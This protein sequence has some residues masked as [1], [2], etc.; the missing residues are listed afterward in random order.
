MIYLCSVNGEIYIESSIELS[1]L[2]AK[3]PGNEL[4]RDRKGHGANWPDSY[5]RLAP[6]SE[7]ARER[8][9]LVPHTVRW[10]QPGSEILV[11]YLPQ[12]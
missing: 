6:W 4:A 10:W 11:K 5:C 1:F 12:I 8:K 7:L 3:V 9:G 2:G